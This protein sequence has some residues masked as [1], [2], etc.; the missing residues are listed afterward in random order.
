[1]K[2]Y[3]EIYFKKLGKSWKYHGILSVQISGNPDP[4]MQWADTSPPTEWLT[5]RCKNITL[6]QTSFAFGKKS[7]RSEYSLRCK[8]YPLYNI[9]ILSKNLVEIVIENGTSQNV[10]CWIGSTPIFEALQYL[11]LNS[12]IIKDKNFVD[13]FSLFTHSELHC[14]TVRF[15][16]ILVCLIIRLT[17]LSSEKCGN[18]QLSL[19]PI[20]RTDDRQL[21]QTTNG[22]KGAAFTF[23][24]VMPG[25]YKGA[26]TIMWCGTCDTLS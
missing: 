23:T 6:P 15:H 13:I 17:C 26:S 18:L 12:L 16:D 2:K 25:K 8:R 3:L 14:A 20:G 7:V 5:D 24:E 11:C 9:K 1:M 22:P 19:S 21:T 10:I 4:S